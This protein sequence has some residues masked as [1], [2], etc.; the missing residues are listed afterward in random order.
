M[1][2]S[3]VNPVEI[4]DIHQLGGE[5]GIGQGL[6]RVPLEWQGQ[7]LRP[8]ARRLQLRL[9]VLGQHLCAAIAERYLGVQYQYIHAVTSRAGISGVEVADDLCQV[10]VLEID[11]GLAPV[12]GVIFLHGDEAPQLL[13]IALHARQVEQGPQ[14]AR[15]HSRAAAARTAVRWRR[16]AAAP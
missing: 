1:T 7:Y 6:L 10:L 15:Y 16:R 5:H 2:W 4:A 8:V 14:V 13:Y 12:I 3:I 9:Q 11:D